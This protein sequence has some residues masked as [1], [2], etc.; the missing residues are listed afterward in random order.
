MSQLAQVVGLDLDYSQGAEHVTKLAM[1]FAEQEQ[2]GLIVGC[3]LGGWLSAQVGAKL[4]LPFVALNPST[5]PGQ[6]LSRYIGEGET[7]NG[8]PFH[9]SEGVVASYPDIE[10]SGKGLALLQKG[11]DVL[12]AQASY[13][14]LKGHYETHLFAGGC[15]RFDRLENHL[16][17]IKKWYQLV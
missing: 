16:A 9:M 8:K 1:Q 4:G 12:D 2:V 7:F 14:L 6:T 13:E 5:Q 15:H 10:L 3:S 11:D 17:L